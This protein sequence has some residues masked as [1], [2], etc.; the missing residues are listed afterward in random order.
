MKE[1][2]YKLLKK[3]GELSDILDL[4]QYA[5]NG[6]IEENESAECLN[7][8]MKIIKTKYRKLHKLIDQININ[9]YQREQY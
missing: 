2:L 9:T 4:M 6:Y 7:D 3:S 8:L 5:L 1:Q